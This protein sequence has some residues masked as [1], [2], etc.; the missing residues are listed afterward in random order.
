MDLLALHHLIPAAE[1]EEG[2]TLDGVGSELRVE[3]WSA[4]DYAGALWMK[5]WEKDQWEGL[6]SQEVEGKR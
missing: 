5:L 1:W 3:M 4:D 6:N 2:K